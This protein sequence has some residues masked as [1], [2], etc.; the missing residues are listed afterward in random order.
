[1]AG[2]DL[3]LVGLPN[4]RDLG[5]YPAAE[6][7][8]VREGMVEMYRQ[9]VADAASRA[10]FAAALALIAERTAQG[11]AVL[12]HCTA[13]KDRTGWLAAVLLTALG[14]DRATVFE[15]YLLTNC[16]AAEGR[17]AES[18][19]EL[20]ATLRR[21]VGERQPIEPLIEVREEYLQAAFDE[22]EARYGSMEA[23]PAEGLGVDTAA[24]RAH[25]LD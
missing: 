19:A 13:G 4:A 16:R 15:D 8:R 21:L 10:A 6:G 2:R 17:G 1:M 18:R 22:A 11:V 7:R 20:L 14:A 3:G 24:L 23:F 25:L 9:F 12:F 5:G